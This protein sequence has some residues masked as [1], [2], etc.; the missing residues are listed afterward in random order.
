M[1]SNIQVGLCKLIIAGLYL[2]ESSVFLVS[3][4]FHI[5]MD[6]EVH[7][8]FYG[9]EDIYNGILCACARQLVSGLSSG[10]EGVSWDEG[11]V[12]I[13]VVFYTTDFQLVYEMYF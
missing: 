8:A 12:C 1:K 4:I 10:W 13:P 7:E 2:K 6:K 11:R 5:Y 3:L 9:W